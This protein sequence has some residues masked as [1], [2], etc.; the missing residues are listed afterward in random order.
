MEDAQGLKF[1]FR[2]GFSRSLSEPRRPQWIRSRFHRNIPPCGA[3]RWMLD[4]TAINHSQDDMKAPR[5]HGGA[6]RSHQEAEM[7]DFWQAANSTTERRQDRLCSRGCFTSSRLNRSAE[8]LNPSIVRGYR[9]DMFTVYWSVPADL[10]VKPD[11]GESKS[12]GIINELLL[13]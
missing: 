10:K 9:T 5:G 7:D 12:S 13:V 3:G 4:I 8:D 11:S 2:L 6:L 1:L